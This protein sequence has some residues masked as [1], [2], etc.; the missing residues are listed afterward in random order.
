VSPDVRKCF[1]SDLMEKIDPYIE[2][3]FKELKIEPTPIRVKLLKLF[4][5]DPLKAM[6]H[7]EALLLVKEELPNVSASVV[8]SSLRLFKARK[9]L[10][11]INPQITSTSKRGRPETRFVFTHGK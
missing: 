7:A 10:K 8:A 1:V 11:E 4:V 2:Q 5:S 6:S 9:I 3:L